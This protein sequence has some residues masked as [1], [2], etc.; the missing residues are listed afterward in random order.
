MVLILGYKFIG[1]LSPSFTYRPFMVHGTSR[2][3]NLISFPD[4]STILSTTLFTR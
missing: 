4:I 3:W 2:L 1:G